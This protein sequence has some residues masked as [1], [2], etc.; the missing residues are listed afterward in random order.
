MRIHDQHVAIARQAIEAARIKY[1]A[2]KVP[3]QDMLKAQVALTRA[4]GAHDPLR[5][6]R[7]SGAGA[8]QHAAGARSQHA[9]P[10]ALGEYAVL[11]ALPEAQTLEELALQSRPDLIAAEQ[12]AERS[13]KEQALAKKAYVPDFTVSAGY[14]IMPSS[15]NFRNAYMVEGSMNLPWLNH[16]K[17]DAEIAE[18]TVQATEQDAELTAMRNAAFGQIQEALVEAE[19]AQ[20]LAHAVSRPTPSPGRS[21][22]PVER[23]CV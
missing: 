10:R 2:G 14:M 18:A 7:R 1:T 22:A 20:K 6:R 12:A 21:H 8:A 15:Q 16:R 19:A 17:H 23:D 11:A 4:G 3:Q 9:A 5:P 13:H